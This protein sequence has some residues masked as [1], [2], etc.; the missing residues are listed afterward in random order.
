M[1][2]EIWILILWSGVVYIN[3]IKVPT[4]HHMQ[5]W[6]NC[7]L[8]HCKSIRPEVF[9][10]KKGF[11][12]NFAEL[13]GRP[14]YRS[15]FLIKLQFLVLKRKM[16]MA[17]FCHGSVNKKI[18]AIYWWKILSETMVLWV[19]V[20]GGFVQ[21]K[22]S[23]AAFHHRNDISDYVIVTFCLRKISQQV[24]SFKKIWTSYKYVGFS[25]FMRF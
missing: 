6:L 23:W 3:V 20:F 11:L 5:L 13:A 24:V 4:L 14:V 25:F 8:N 18:T 7:W 22:W 19:F 21:Y 15:L 12:D 1:E 17:L 2:I 9:W 10:K 16:F